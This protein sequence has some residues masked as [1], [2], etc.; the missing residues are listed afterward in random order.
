MNTT[1][2]VAAFDEIEWRLDSIW[3]LV[4]CFLIFLMQ[5]GFLLLEA[6]SVPE[7]HTKMIM[8]KNISDTC[9]GALGWYFMGHYIY[10]RGTVFVNGDAELSSWITSYVF[11]VTTSTILSGGVACRITYLSYLI[12]STILACWVYPMG[13]RWAWGEGQW[14]HDMGY[15]DFAG[16]GV[17]HTIGGASALVGTMALGPRK[18]RFTPAGED[19]E[20]EGS[21]TT[22]RI[23]GFFVLWFCWYAF[24]AGSSGGVTGPALALAARAAINTLLASASAGCVG[25]F[26]GLSSPR[27]L[28]TILINC[29]L[30]GL[31]AITAGCAFVDTYSAISIGIGG[32]V[33]SNLTSL[34]LIKRQID[35]PV[36]AFASFLD[37]FGGVIDEWDSLRIRDFSRSALK[38][39]L[40]SRIRSIEFHDFSAV[41]LGYK[42]SR[43]R[44]WC[45]AQDRD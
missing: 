28:L 10:T 43:G 25:I 13:A 8:A 40:G 16:N 20:P 29:V 12:Y 31:V 26:I 27:K 5:L 17:V 30:G 9:F 36:D 34:F 41:L 14:L 42:R 24:N 1:D 11:A 23:L 37:L 38:R 6:G 45:R 19:T 7:H 3:I 4:M 33:V 2:I 15:L 39:L 35:D 32:A 18:N 44:F 21:S 22:N